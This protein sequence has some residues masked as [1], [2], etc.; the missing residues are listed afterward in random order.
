[1]DSFEKFSEYKLPD[2][3]KF[4]SCLKNNISEEDYLKG[5]ISDKDYLEG[6]ISAEDY[7]HAIDVWNKFKIKSLV[8]YHDNYLK[9]DVLLLANI[10]D[11]FIHTC[12]II[13]D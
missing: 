9:R 13:M 5:G 6:C 4:Y 7:L 10:F 8:V 12:L 3:S 11:K 2:R 1:M